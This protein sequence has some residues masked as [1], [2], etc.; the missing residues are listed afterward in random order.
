[1]ELKKKLII[2]SIISVLL[3]A[4]G[5]E[6][7]LLLPEN[8]RRSDIVGL[9]KGL[10][11]NKVQEGVNTMEPITVTDTR[12]FKVHDHLTV[13]S[14]KFTLNEAINSDEMK[15]AWMN[16]ENQ[17]T[18]GLSGFVFLMLFN[19]DNWFGHAHATA[20]S[21]GSFLWD[22]Y[23]RWPHRNESKPIEVVLIHHPSP[24]WLTENDPNVC[25]LC[26]LKKPK[27]QEEPDCEHDDWA[28]CHSNV[29]E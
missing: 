23:I 2:Y 22:P 11:R 18:H 15:N 7:P 5:I 19:N 24:Y 13:R 17:L 29:G 14:K 6:L 27:K 9:V 16:V 26:S 1:M 28:R 8:I 20:D 12:D 3:L 25:H 21:E 4:I 10:K